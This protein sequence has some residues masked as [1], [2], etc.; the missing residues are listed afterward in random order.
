LKER[1]VLVV[2][3]LTHHV[4]PNETLG[5]ESDSLVLT[6]E[7]R[8]WVRGRFTT[9]KGR[10]IA[11]ALPT[12]S[13]LE[14]GSILWVGPEWYL[15][16]EAAPEPVLVIFPADRKDSVRI[17]FEV[18]NR[19]FPLALEENGLLVPDDPAMV[20]LLDRMGATWERRQAIFRPLGNAHRHDH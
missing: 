15:T 6:S 17:A 1:S 20:Q 18:G 8:R 13:T 4:H 16:V 11:L 5:K 19:H 7:Q 3:R 2:D 10:E 12:G 9:A 14:P